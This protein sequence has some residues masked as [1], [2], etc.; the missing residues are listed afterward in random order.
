MSRR[1]GIGT[2][3]LGVSLFAIYA[4]G[5]CPSIYV[6]DSGELVTAVHLLGIRGNVSCA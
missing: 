4:V 3:F 2:L 6:G 1:D 5:A